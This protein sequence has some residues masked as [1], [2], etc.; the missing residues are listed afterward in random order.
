M[1]IENRL[2]LCKALC[3]TD[4]AQKNIQD[5]EK[6]EIEQDAVYDYITQGNILQSKGTWYK[7]GEKNNK[8]FLSLE[9]NRNSKIVFES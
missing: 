8:Y 2:K 9:K 6:S 7:K 4:P 3:A 5:L 1:V